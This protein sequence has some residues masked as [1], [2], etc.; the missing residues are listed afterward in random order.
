MRRQN[1]KRSRLLSMWRII[2]RRLYRRIAAGEPCIEDLI[3]IPRPD[4]PVEI[5]VPCK[6][7]GSAK[8]ESLNEHID[9]LL[10]QGYELR[11]VLRPRGA[12]EEGFRSCHRVEAVRK[13]V[14]EQPTKRQ[15]G[16][17]K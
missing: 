2:R 8:C 3:Y 7:C 6:E 9:R 5:E 10:S 13:R 11:L 1:H 12:D 14:P 15:E 16:L 17:R 4:Q